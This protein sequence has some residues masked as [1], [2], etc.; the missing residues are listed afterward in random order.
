MHSVEVSP[1]L[2]DG[3][4]NEVLASIKVPYPVQGGT[5]NTLQ[6]LYEDYPPAFTVVTKSTKDIRQIVKNNQLESQDEG[7]PSKPKKKRCRKN[8]KRRRRRGR[9]KTKY[10]HSDHSPVTHPP[11]S[12]AD[13][14]RQTN[15]ALKSHAK[16]E[17]HALFNS[18]ATKSLPV[19]GFDG[20]MA[21]FKSIYKPHR[22]SQAIS[23]ATRSEILIFTD[24]KYRLCRRHH[25]TF[26]MRKK[27][28]LT[29]YSVSSKI[30]RLT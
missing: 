5:V 25:T 11:P 17:F 22:Q 13:T 24:N 27:Q 9:H 20:P 2:R 4:T 8:R 26:H 23:C 18:A 29:P 6:C 30:L 7:L 28:Y 15:T 14:R 19:S 12:P 21:T 1:P 3:V 16:K 10:D